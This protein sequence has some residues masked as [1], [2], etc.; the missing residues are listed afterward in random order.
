MWLW[1][2]KRSYLGLGCETA[3]SL[4]GLASLIVVICVCS[5]FIPLLTCGQRTQQHSL[6]TTSGCTAMHQ[7]TPSRRSVGVKMY[8]GEIGLTKTGSFSIQTV[9]FTSRKYAWKTVAATTVSQPTML[10]WNRAS[11][12][13]TF[14]VSWNFDV[15][16]CTFC[17]A[18]GFDVARQGLKF[19][20]VDFTVW[21]AST[22]RIW[23]RHSQCIIFYT[24]I[25]GTNNIVIELC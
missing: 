4:Q 1:A 8:Q 19:C 9:H 24:V 13:L 11:S 25:W 14:R 20:L 23:I 2:V 22:S 17:D 18:L 12:A 5:Q 16:A 6:T 7:V 21:P 10:K 3:F 15:H